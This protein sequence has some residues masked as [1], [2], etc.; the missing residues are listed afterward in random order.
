MHFLSIII[1][2]DCGATLDFFK[3]FCVFQNIAYICSPKA[4]YADVVKW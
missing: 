3:K 1:N 2:D 4:K